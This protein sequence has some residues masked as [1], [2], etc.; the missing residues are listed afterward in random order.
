[1]KYA[2]GILA[3]LWLGLIGAQVYTDISHANAATAFISACETMG[4]QA[5]V[6]N[7]GTKSCLK[8]DVALSAE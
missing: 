2:I 7:Y 6:G 8:A 5:I 1:M 4:G 3:A